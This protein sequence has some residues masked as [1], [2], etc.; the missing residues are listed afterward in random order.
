M[1]VG[2]KVWWRGMEGCWAKCG[3]K[4]RTSLQLKGS[5]EVSIGSVQARNATATSCGVFPRTSSVRKTSEV[6]ALRTNEEASWSPRTKLVIVTGSDS[7]S[8]CTVAGLPSRKTSSC[9]VAKIPDGDQD[10][11]VAPCWS[12]FLPATS[13]QKVGTDR[14]LNDGE[15]QSQLKPFDM[16]LQRK[17]LQRWP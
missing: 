11:D 13:S 4:S 15:D 1:V 6:T 12:T 7:G 8:Y 10:G 9:P 5:G 16:L 17:R 3:A 2:S 14:N